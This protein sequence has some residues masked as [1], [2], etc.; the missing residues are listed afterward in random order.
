MKK[1]IVIL[2]LSLAALLI[3]G[4][5][6][7]KNDAQTVSPSPSASPSDHIGT[8]QKE[9]NSGHY[10]ADDSG[11]VGNDHENRTENKEDGVLNDVGEAVDDLVEDAKR[12]MRDMTR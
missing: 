9:E 11:I 2:S 12:G 3:L 4:G 5:C 7:G 6:M 1:H 10:D 8:D